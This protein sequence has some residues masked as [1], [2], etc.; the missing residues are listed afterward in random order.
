MYNYFIALLQEQSAASIWC[1]FLREIVNADTSASVSRVV[2]GVKVS[3]TN[4]VS[5]SIKHLPFGI[6]LFQAG[7]LSQYGSSAQ[8]VYLYRHFAYLLQ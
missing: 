8:A 5:P 7:R 3:C 6:Q 2:L 1:T 4:I